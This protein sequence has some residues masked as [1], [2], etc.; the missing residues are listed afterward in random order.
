MQFEAVER[1]FV[2]F[3]IRLLSV[4][5]PSPVRFEPSRRARSYLA[6]FPFS[7]L[8]PHVK[9]LPRLTLGV[10][11]V[12]L[13][14]DLLCDP[15]VRD[16]KIIE[17]YENPSLSYLSE[18]VAL[19]RRHLPGF[20]LVF[21]LRT[22]AQGGRYPY[23]ADAPA[24]ALF[25]SLHHALKLG[26]DMIDIEMGLEEHLTANLIQDAKERNTSV[27]ISWRDTSPP[28]EGGF[29][30]SSTEAKALYDEAMQMGADVVKIVGTAGQISDNFALRLFAARIEEEGSL[31]NGETGKKPSLSAYNMGS[32]GR[33]S[34]FLN[35]TLASVTHDVAKQLTGKG[36][37]GNPSMTFN[38]I[39]RALHLSGLLEK[40][41]FLYLCSSQGTAGDQVSQLY[42]D[43][44]DVMGLPYC[45]DAQMTNGQELRELLFQ[46]DAR[47]GDLQGVVVGE[48]V[49]VMKEVDGDANV[50]QTGYCDTVIVDPVGHLLGVNKLVEALHHLIERSIS[51]SVH[52]NKESS[53]VIVS[54]SA[55]TSAARSAMQAVK[56]LGLENVSLIVP[57]ATTALALKHKLPTIVIDACE[58]AT[59]CPLPIY[60]ELLS[61]Q[62]GGECGKNK[63]REHR[64]TNAVHHA[65]LYVDLFSNTRVKT[66][67]QV[68]RYKQM[69]WRH[70]GSDTVSH[71][72]QSLRFW[73]FTG[74]RA[75]S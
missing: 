5:E 16:A 65:G 30:W 23:P 39:Q 75:P 19:V 73:H 14:A 17:A 40:K 28:K 34:R 6:T 49:D 15:M 22:P 25:K 67:L 57:S 3:L 52:F 45:M 56:C 32:K 27:L 70:I 74:R 38:E 12:E 61:G 4:Y 53:A 66:L 2:S 21:T 13:R 31:S 41:S 54:S 47:N 46:H 68:E 63:E 29:D 9:E 58:D 48:G 20:P 26:C 36:I 44:F 42:R 43:W 69:G 71:Q 51:P 10:D 7:D 11:A 64:D 8:S 50:E 35:S 33:I 55:S 24:E 59:M 18:Q 1:D 62:D 60:Y 72:T 37:I